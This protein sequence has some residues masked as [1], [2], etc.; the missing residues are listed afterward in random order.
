V[1]AFFQKHR[2]GL[3]TLVFTDLV[4][5]TALLQQ[6]GDQDGASF[7]RRRRQILREVLHSL[8]EA[9]EIETAGDSFLLVFAKPS[10]AVRF[11]LQS[12]ARLR[13]FSLESR[14]KVQERMG[15][16][17][18]EVVI[19][20]RETE[21]KAK[22]LYG[23]PLAVCARVMSLAV[24]GQVLLTRGAFD[25]A[26]QV[27]RGED[28]PGVGGLRWVSHG[29]YVLKGI[30]EPVEV[31][32]VAESGEAELVAPKT[33]EKA[34]RQVRADEEPVLGWRP[35]VGQGVPNTGWVLEKKLGEG[36]FGEVWLGRHQ[37]TK[38]RRVFKFCFRADRVRSLKREMTLFRLIKE[39][40]GDHPNIVALREVFFDA[41]P[42]YVEI[43]YVASLDL[44]GWCEA[45]GG[46]AQVPEAM[47]FEIIAQV[48]EAL[49]AAHQAGVIHRDIKPGNI[50]IAECGVRSAE[51]EKLN[52]KSQI[53]AK[54]TDFGIGQVVSEEYL[55]GVTRAGFTETLM[56]SGSSS[57]TG[58]QLYLAPELLTGE[59]ATPRSDIYSLGV[60]LYQLTAGA[61]NRALT[62][63]WAEDISDLPLREVIRKA[64][65]GKPQLRF[66]SASEL[67]QRLRSL[68]QERAELAQRQRAGRRRRLLFA[69]GAL[70]LTFALMWIVAAW[71]LSHSRMQWATYEALP[72]VEQFIDKGR[73]DVADSKWWRQAL[74]L[75]QSAQRYVPQSQ[76]QRLEK[77]LN[78]CSRV[79][80][81]Q[82][83]P[84]GATVSLKPYDDQSV[85]W[86]T[87]GQTP[88]EHVR[89]ARGF[90]VLRFEKTGYEPVDAVGSSFFFG[91]TNIV[92][93]LDPINV[94]P[95][96]MTRV[97]GRK[98]VG[99]DNWPDFFIDK[100]EVTNR[101]YKE[102]IDAGGYRTNRYWT[103]PFVRDGKALSWDEAMMLFRDSTGQPGPAEW[104]AGKFP[105][106]QDDFPV[107]GVNWFEAAAY[108]EFVRKSLPT[109]EHWGRAAGLD[110]SDFEYVFTTLIARLS[111]FTN[112]P[113][114]GP[115]AVGSHPGLNAFGAYDMAGNVR[116]W[117]STASSSGA[118]FIRGG[119]WDD[120]AYMY[121]DESQRSP[122]DRSPGNGFRCVSYLG[123]DKVPPALFAPAQPA[124]PHDFAKDHPVPDSVFEIYKA[125]FKYDH[126]PLDAEKQERDESAPD[127]VREQVSFAAAYE[128]ERVIVQ[129]FLPR[130]WRQPFQTIIYFPCAWARE[131]RQS[132][133]ARDLA[134]TLD[135]FLRS[136]R[137]V[138]LPAYKGTYE[139]TGKMTAADWWPDEEHRY[140]YTGYLVAYVKDLARCL[141]YLETRP[142]EFDLQKIASFGFSWGAE[143][144]LIIPAVEPR[145][146]ANILF[147]GGFSDGHAQPEAQAINY[148]SHITVPT[149][150]L[151]GRLDMNFPLETAVRPA[152]NLFGTPEKDKHLVIY[153]TD[154]YVPKKE[155]RKESLE[156]L[157][158]YFGPPLR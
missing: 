125:Q 37:H 63:D 11:A 2:T 108:A 9:E 26:R 49:E 134:F 33:S 88:L 89:V 112:G 137:A 146:K 138:V 1:A 153:D 5:S 109:S 123:R 4:D 120:V 121:S 99:A 30:E 55:I 47:K 38:E 107:S 78:N 142:E 148:I 103:Q 151:N 91:A 22:D 84:S 42:F 82:S 152:L 25:S 106:G 54:L 44:R 145:I 97:P 60:V 87:L 19:S 6:L 8:P 104:V 80:S 102:F 132:R 67:A 17:L 65:A 141:D 93:R 43:D 52:Q 21:M 95:T 32:E 56:S 14:L 115:G 57:R 129:L 34:Q 68:P 39:R 118:R 127:W 143:L 140:A 41:P 35:A 40:I 124:S 59:P 94:I 83:E 110:V 149:L 147:L 150:M 86:I 18:G 73:E 119:A 128:N 70:A 76:S 36:G 126:T 10:D 96:G 51:G 61:F 111:N 66:D 53:L 69:G 114:A 98:G 62:S 157:N 50:L 92:R 3:V 130:T 15:I 81:I 105:R 139:R 48:A 144:G 135:F 12:H 122:W 100:Y 58:T 27:L 113:A 133:E 13:T 158:R 154:H 71:W 131:D 31:C 90:F 45:Q 79:L 101:R 136:G 64:V 85:R 75:A 116:E 117:C 156:W 16:H 28:I 72:Q 77:A 23:I 20:E 7:L 29:P 24:G 46:A 155:V 74:E